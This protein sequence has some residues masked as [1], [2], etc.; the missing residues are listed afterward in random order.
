MQPPDTRGRMFQRHPTRPPSCTSPTPEP[1]RSRTTP[2]APPRG[3]YRRPCHVRPSPSPW[4][5]PPE[6]ASTGASCKVRGVR[7]GECVR[8]VR[9]ARPSCP[10][11]HVCRLTR[12]DPRRS[13]C[14]G[15][16]LVS[17]GALARGRRPAHGRRALLQ[18]D[19][20]L[21]SGVRVTGDPRGVAGGCPSGDPRVDPP[22]QDG[23][24]SAP[25]PTPL[26]GSSVP[27][28]RPPPT[29][30]ARRPQVG[31]PGSTGVPERPPTKSREGV[32]LHRTSVPGAG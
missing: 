9:A 2:P 26:P 22:P 28:P 12:D 24:P 19:V 32:P 16:P 3:R 7:C 5:L 25:V 30:V 31:P 4:S 29:L 11:T 14:N 10:E 21:S 1:G 17:V 8:G 18:A 23:D 15:C 20:S 27:G 6:P 13:Q